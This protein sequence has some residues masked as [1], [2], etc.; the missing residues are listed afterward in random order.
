MATRVRALAFFN[1]VPRRPDLSSNGVA[2]LLLKDE[3]PCSW[4]VPPLCLQMRGVFLP[5]ASR[6]QGPWRERE[7]KGYRSRDLRFMQ[8]A[9]AALIAS[10]SRDS[11]LSAEDASDV[12]TQ[13]S[14]IIVVKAA[15]S[16]DSQQSVAPMYRRLAANFIDILI[17]RFINLVFTLALKLASMQLGRTVSDDVAKNFGNLAQVSSSRALAR[18]KLCSLVR[19]LC[20]D[21]E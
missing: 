20:T 15:S 19:L 21:S 7:E 3:L 18:Y 17:A 13:G 5:P 6:R 14:D 1:M 16:D 12:N 9:V 10:C 8:G 4:R 11:A 2:G